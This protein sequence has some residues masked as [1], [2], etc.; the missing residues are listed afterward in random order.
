MLQFRLTAWKVPAREELSCV[1]LDGEPLAGD[2]TNIT[3]PYYEIQNQQLFLP[4]EHTIIAIWIK[5][6]KT[7]T[8][9]SGLPFTIATL[10][11]VNRH[12]GMI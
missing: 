6:K 4:G 2:S 5:N 7:Y 12:N 8:E 3:G 11:W 10:N 1:Q 9:T